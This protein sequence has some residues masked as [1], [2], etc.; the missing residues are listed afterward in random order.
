[1]LQDPRVFI[2]DEATASVDPFTEEQIQAG[3][4]A[5]MEGRT[6]I[7]IAHR[8]STVRSADR[9]IVMRQGQIIE[10]GSHEGL[11]AR[12]GHYAELY[13]TYFRHQSLE[14]IEAVGGFGE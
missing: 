4:D 13:T 7:V 2:L 5:V 11:L 3:L 6:S 1:M 10:E 12:G 9:I 8:L 14:Y